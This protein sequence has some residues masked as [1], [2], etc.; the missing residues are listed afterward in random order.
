[1][2]VPTIVLQHADAVTFGAIGPS[3]LGRGTKLRHVVSGMDY[4]DRALPGPA[5]F[6]ASVVRLGKA[7]FVTV[8][9]ERFAVTRLGAQAARRYAQPARGVIEQAYLLGQA[10]EGLELDEV[11]HD[12]E[13]HIASSEWDK[14]VE[15]YGRFV[16]RKRWRLFLPW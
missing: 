5:E 8:N 12:F 1:V 13:F 9:S 16:S 2:D 6:E 10:W 14:A 7:G 3:R 11:N 15:A 4:L